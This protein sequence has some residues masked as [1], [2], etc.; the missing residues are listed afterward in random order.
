VWELLLT[1]D[2]SCIDRGVVS[3]ALT[4]AGYP[5]IGIVSSQVA[6]YCFYDGWVTEYGK[7]VICEHPWSG[8]R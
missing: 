1:C 7:S 5:L 4:V 6:G 2:G 8:M 3:D